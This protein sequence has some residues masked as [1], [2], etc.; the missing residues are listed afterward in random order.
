MSPNL[1]HR[2]FGESFT[3]T[4][5]NSIFDTPLRHHTPNRTNLDGANIFTKS[6]NAS[7]LSAN[8]LNRKWND[9]YQEGHEAESPQFDENFQT[10]QVNRAIESSVKSS[11]LRPRNLH[12]NSGLEDSPYETRR[13]Y[14]TKDDE[15][16]I[17]NMTPLQNEVKSISQ[18]SSK[19]PIPFPKTEDEVTRPKMAVPDKV[20][21]SDKGAIPDK[22]GIP[23]DFRFLDETKDRSLNKNKLHEVGKENGLKKAVEISSGKEDLADVIKRFKNLKQKSKKINSWEADLDDKNYVAGDILPKDENSDIV[24]DFKLIQKDKNSNVGFDS[25][26]RKFSLEFDN[27]T[28]S[29]EHNSFLEIA[30]NSAK[31]EIATWSDL[32]SQITADDDDMEISNSKLDSFDDLEI[33]V[34]KQLSFVQL[35]ARGISPELRHINRQP[36]ARTQIVAKRN[37]DHGEQKDLDLLFGFNSPGNFE[38]QSRISSQ[39]YAAD[40]SLLSDTQREARSF[41]NV[42]KVRGEENGIEASLKAWDRGGLRTRPRLESDEPEIPLLKN[43]SSP[44]IE[45]HITNLKNQTKFYNESKNDFSVNE[46]PKLKT[47]DD[48]FNIFTPGLKLRRDL[49]KFSLDMDSPGLDGGFHGKSP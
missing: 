31:K 46:T 38:T 19:S 44:F 33:P 2:L 37:V 5:K 47:L 36:V 23:D 26:M 18:S 39:S 3:E 28:P 35:D 9:F 29:Q 8:D 41:E 32:K 22:V 43:N 42:G 45:M 40:N 13:Q 7:R 1:D 10:P 27:G 25:A 11:I 14:D 15:E 34:A 20:A 48:S 17:M 21:V 24:D 49:E 12:E 16:S 30:R 4:P 6:K